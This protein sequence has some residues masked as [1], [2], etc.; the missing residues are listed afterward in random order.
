M[1]PNI[2]LSTLPARGATEVTTMRYR[3]KYISIHAPREGSDAGLRPAAACIRYFYPRSPRGERRCQFIRVVEGAAFLSTLPA[4]G[5]T[6]KNVHNRRGDG[7]FYPRSPR[8][9]RPAAARSWRRRAKISIHAPREGSDLAAGEFLTAVNLFLST[10]PARGAT[11]GDEVSHWS[12]SNFYPRSPRGERPE[13]GLQT[14]NAYRN[15]YPRSPRGER[16]QMC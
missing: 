3:I 4:R 9:E 11:D 5:A 14:F 15:F 16:Q 1:D 7:D 8:G 6:D 12:S 13:G 2:F 10:L